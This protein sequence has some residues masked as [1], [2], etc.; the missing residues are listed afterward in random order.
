MTDFKDRNKLSNAL[1]LAID[2]AGT[3]IA[4]V[5]AQIFENPE[6]AFEEVQAATLLANT[7]A[8]HGYEV[9]FELAGLK[10]AFQATQRNFDSEAMRKGL[11]HGH[12]AIL[13]EYDADPA[14][15]QSGRHLV[16]GAALASAIGLAE[17]LKGVHGQVTIVGCPAASTG[18]GK[19]HLAA[20]GVFEPFDAVLGA[21]PASTGEG[22]QSIINSTGDTMAAAQVQVEFSGTGNVEQAQQ[23]FLARIGTL[24]D[25]GAVRGV[26]DGATV[27][28]DLR[29][30]TNPDMDAL[31]AQVREVAEQPA[32]S[33]DV[34]ASVEVV[35][36]TPAMLVNR[37]LARRVKTFTDSLQVKQD[38]VRKMAPGEPSDWGHVSLVSSTVQARY[39]VSEDAVEVGT[40]A[41]A[42]AST[43]DFAQQ[44]MRSTAIAVALTSLDLLG[45]MELRGFA[46]GEL[47]RS[48]NAQGITRT[49]RR[50]LGVHPV[51]PRESS[52]GH[53][54]T[55]STSGR[56]NGGS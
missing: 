33:G 36:Q 40:E 8:G 21:V 41:F 19:R 34:S 5:C 25:E 47:I 17:A 48:L 12:V 32:G 37:I 13:A 39:P 55:A 11:R 49:P 44:Q 56:R 16:A 24:S 26:A 4:T 29:A 35:A 28:V 45:D 9:E 31:L 14:G 51:Q 22:F 54:S 42:I 52:N 1:G 18:E 7:L 50:W 10:T 15:H 30:A 20:A 2:G 38:Q 53:S 46:E 6:P 43:S 3:D 27:S 23:D